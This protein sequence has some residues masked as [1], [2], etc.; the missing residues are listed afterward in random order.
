MCMLS[1][2][3]HFVLVMENQAAGSAAAGAPSEQFLIGKKGAFD[4]NSL[5]R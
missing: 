4:V 2:L 3:F 5:E 1:P